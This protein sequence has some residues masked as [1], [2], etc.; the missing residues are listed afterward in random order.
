MPNRHAITLMLCSVTGTSNLSTEQSVKSPHRNKS[1]CSLLNILYHWHQIQ[2]S[3]SDSLLWLAFCMRMLFSYLC[4]PMA[5]C[6]SHSYN[7]NMS[8][9][10]QNTCL[11]HNSFYHKTTLPTTS[12]RQTGDSSKKQKKARMPI[13]K[14]FSLFTQ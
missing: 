11:L 10:P 5:A 6:L 1:L 2:G 8:A 3:Y 4:R 12:Y 13:V 9:T 7:S 14:A